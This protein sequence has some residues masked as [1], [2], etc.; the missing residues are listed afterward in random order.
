MSLQEEI[1]AVYD[2]VILS[3]LKA[4]MMIVFSLKYNEL[5]LQSKYVIIILIHILLEE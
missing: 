4:F 2:L 5:M 3:E 1:K